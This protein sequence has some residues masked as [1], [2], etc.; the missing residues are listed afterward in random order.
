MK[1]DEL[2]LRIETYASSVIDGVFGAGGG[3][4]E[5]LKNN[6]AKFWVKQNL[7]RLDDMLKPFVDNNGEI[8]VE[9]AKNF[10][11]DALFDEKGSFTLVLKD[12]VP[13]SLKTVVPDKVVVF[14][15][16]DIRKLLG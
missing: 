4:F 14:T 6:A 5:K 8:D 13:E 3:V 16:E 15:K 11:E 12:V 2:K 9:T 1:I 7:W 10:I